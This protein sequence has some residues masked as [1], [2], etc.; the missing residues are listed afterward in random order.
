MTVEMPVGL[1]VSRPAR[2]TQY[3]CV[4]RSGKTFTVAAAC[5]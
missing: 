5:S 2:N 1:T 4:T 3:L